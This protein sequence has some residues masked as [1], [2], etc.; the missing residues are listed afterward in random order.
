MKK[1]RCESG[2]QLKKE[3][4]I[5]KLKLRQKREGQMKLRQKRIELQ[6]NFS[7]SLVTY[8]RGGTQ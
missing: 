6:R 7:C 1:C 5:R 4:K 8:L 3:H 2:K